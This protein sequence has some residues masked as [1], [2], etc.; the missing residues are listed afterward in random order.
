MNTAITMRLICEKDDERITCKGIQEH[1]TNNEF[2]KTKKINGDPT[3]HK[4]KKN[5]IKKEFTTFA[6]NLTETIN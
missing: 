3:K 5:K 4:P 6:Y 1:T 2:C